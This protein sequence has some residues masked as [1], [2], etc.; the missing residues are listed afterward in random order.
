[1]NRSV[2]ALAV[3]CAA[4]AGAVVALVAGGNDKTTTVVTAPGKSSAHT[5]ASGHAAISETVAAPKRLVRL[6]VRPLEQTAEGVV[7]V[8][9]R[10]TRGASVTV[11]GKKARVRQGVYRVRLKLR[12]GANRFTVIAR[13][14]DRRTRRRPVKVTRVQPAPVAAP[15]EQGCGGDPYAYRSS[16]GTCVGPAHPPS[17]GPADPSDC[18]AGQVPVG[19]TGACAPPEDG[20]SVQPDTNGAKDPCPSGTNF[21][22]GAGCVNGDY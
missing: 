20:S 3:I 15:S 9:G 8:R 19:V 5:T 7:T 11:R 22:D 17:G 14:A 21:V 18:P 10:T 4:L 16:D 6:S 12:L 2:I 13:H 1:M